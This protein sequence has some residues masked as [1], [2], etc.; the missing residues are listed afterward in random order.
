MFVHHIGC[1]GSMP[2]IPCMG[3]RLEGGA[4]GYWTMPVK[5]AFNVIPEEELLRWCD[6]V[7]HIRYPI[8]AA[9]VDAISRD[10]GGPH[11]TEIAR[12]ILE[13]S[14]DRVQV[15]KTFIRQFSLPC[16]DAPRTGE[17]Q[18]DLRL[19]DEMAAF[20]DTGLEEFASKEKARLSEAIAAARQTRPTSFMDIDEGGFE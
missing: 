4:S 15:L 5:H 7:P 17:A 18:A 11:W 13:K 8:A 14:S 19:L 1:F 10:P 16:W 6:E 3:N 2:R 9:G 12:K 20:S